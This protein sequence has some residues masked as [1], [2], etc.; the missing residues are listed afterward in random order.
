MVL[1]AGVLL[2][3]SIGV[4]R[5]PCAQAEPSAPAEMKFVNDVHSHMQSYGDTRVD[6]VRNADLVG[7]GWSA[8][9]DF[10]IGVSPQQQGIDPLIAHYAKVDLCP[11]G[12]PEGCRGIW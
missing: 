4:V 5:A 8:C 2:G 3:A 9:H 1:F 7:E 11:N 6:R 10:A 12:C